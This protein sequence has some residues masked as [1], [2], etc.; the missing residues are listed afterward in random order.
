AKRFLRPRLDQLNDP[1]TL[2]DLGVAVDRIVRAIRER[3]TILV[4]GDYDVDGISST[5]ILTRTLRWLGGTVVPFIP[6]RS[7]GYDLTA[8]G[9]RAAKNAGARLVITCDC[10]TSA[11]APIADLRASGVDVIVTDHH[12]PGGPLPDAL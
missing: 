2:G 8:A 1:A 11:L 12:L 6:H 4:H 7:D 9:V 5:T 10:G 3:E